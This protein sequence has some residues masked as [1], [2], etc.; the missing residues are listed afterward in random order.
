MAQPYVQMSLQHSG[1]PVYSMTPKTPRARAVFLDL[2]GTLIQVRGGIGLQY[3]EIAR[4]YGVRAEPDAITAAFPAALRAAGRMVFVHPDA[5]EVASLEKGFWKNVVRSVFERA[6][7]LQQFE[8]A[9]FD[10]C[11]ERLFEYFATAAGWSIYPDVRP[12]LARLRKDRLIVGLIT[13][14]DARVFRLIDAL[15]LSGSIDSIMIPSLAGAAKPE[16]RI[17]ECALSAHRLAAHEA[18]QVGDSIGDDVEGAR[19]AGM[20]GILI[21]RAGRNP[22]GADVITTLA[23]LPPLLGLA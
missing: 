9:S 15:G 13:N 21:D 20:R 10:R 23:D 18:V 8:G 4:E 2:A 1:V 11:F 3:A 5:A 22:G 17:F 19:A 16:P 6:G 14:F 12:A 7:A